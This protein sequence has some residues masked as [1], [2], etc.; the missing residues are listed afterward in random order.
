MEFAFKKYHD[1]ISSNVTN[2]NIPRVDGTAKDF[3]IPVIFY[4]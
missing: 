1:V 3:Y 4:K 2:P